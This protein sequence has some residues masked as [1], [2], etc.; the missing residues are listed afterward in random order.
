MVAER[1]EAQAERAMAEATVEA[2][3]LV[4]VVAVVKEVGAP[5]VA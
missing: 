1:V 4:V 3:G 2:A 5:E